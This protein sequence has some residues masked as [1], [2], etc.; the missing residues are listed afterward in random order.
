M[1]RQMFL[2]F[3]HNL[4]P[5]QQADAQKRFGIENFVPLPD[6]LQRIWSQ[7]PAEAAS[8]DPLLAPV[9][10]WLDQQVE[11]GD[12][13]LVQGDF[14]A[15]CLAVRRLQSRGVLCCYATTRRRAIERHVKDRVVKES[16]F[17]HVRFR[18]YE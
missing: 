18:E 4:T 1:M 3:N 7:I 17:E 13:A 12:V 16:V 15:S 6:D 10:Q 11:E 5:A 2:L 9:W 8:L 14:G